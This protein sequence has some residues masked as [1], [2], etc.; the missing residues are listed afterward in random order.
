MSQFSGPSSGI[1]PGDDVT[2]TCVVDSGAT[3]WTFSP[4]G[5][6]DR[7]CNYLRAFPDQTTCN[8]PDERFRISQTEG[9]ANNSSSLSLA[10]ITENLNE[11]MIVC[12]DGNSGNQVGTDNICIVGKTVPQTLM[13]A[14]DIFLF[15]CLSSTVTYCQ[16]S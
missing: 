15:R 11:T 5:E 1:C 13:L 14:S 9:S 6:S 8:P 4:P 10:S 7:T 16:H 3:R 12:A 2:F